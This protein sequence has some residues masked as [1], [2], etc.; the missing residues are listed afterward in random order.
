MTFF[1]Q[2]ILMRYGYSIMKFCLLCTAK[3]ADVDYEE[4]Y[5]HLVTRQDVL[6]QEAK[7]ISGSLDQLTEEQ[8]KHREQIQNIVNEE[9][10]IEEEI[11]SLTERLQLLTEHRHGY[12]RA[13]EELE[14]QRI[15]ENGRLS[16]V[17]K[18]LLTLQD[19]TEKVKRQFL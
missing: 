2:L 19:E 10:K 12:E 6:Q 11:R 16:L 13:C 9:H 14:E 15:S 17:H 1:S 7:S 8:N 3:K 5:S 18:T 4:K